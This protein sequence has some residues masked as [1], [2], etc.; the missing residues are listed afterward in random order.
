MA[1]YKHKPNTGRLFP[2]DRKKEN[3][4]APNF[5]GTADVRISGEVEIG[6]WVNYEEGTE[7]KV[8]NLYL[9]FSEPYKKD[10]AS[11]GQMMGKKV[12]LISDD[13]PF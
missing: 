12:E 13:M 7:R 5:N 6:V 4:K 9:T 2:N 1:D 3:P 10:G 11:S 8:K